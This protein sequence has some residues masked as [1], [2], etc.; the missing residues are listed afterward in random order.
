MSQVP[1]GTEIPASFDPS[2]STD[3][4]RLD[5]PMQQKQ[6]LI[7]PPPSPPV[8]WEQAVEDA[9]VINHAL[10]EALQRLQDTCGRVDVPVVV[11][12]SENGLP[13]V[14]VIDYCDNTADDGMARRR[15]RSPLSTPWGSHTS[16]PAKE[17]PITSRPP[18][19]PEGQHHHHHAVELVPAGKKIS[20]AALPLWVVQ[21]LRDSETAPPQ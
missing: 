17:L 9:P 13:T 3:I 16:R 4:E 21:A 14:L 11:H 15:V 12:P 20:P 1:E 7:S 2:T 19:R 18:D 8:G 10:A 5:V 6:F